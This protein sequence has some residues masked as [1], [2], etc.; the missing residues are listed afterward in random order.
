MAD[1]VPQIQPH[2]D[3]VMQAEQHQQR[4]AEAGQGV[5]APVPAAMD[6]ET[7]AANADQTMQ[8]EPQ[9]PASPHIRVGNLADLAPMMFDQPD[10][11]PAEPIAHSARAHVVDLEAMTVDGQAVNNDANST[12]G[13]SESKASSS[14]KRRRAPKGRSADEVLTRT[15]VYLFDGKLAMDEKLRQLCEDDRELAEHVNTHA[16]HKPSCHKGVGPDECR[17]GCPCGTVHLAHTLRSRV[18]VFT[19]RATIHK[20]TATTCS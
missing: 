20:S 7:D 13:H 10:A 3:H 9:R 15:P 18:A 4:P 11:Q 17:Y 8:P 2:G 5:V 16:Q 6:I 14:G 12:A 1:A 19:S